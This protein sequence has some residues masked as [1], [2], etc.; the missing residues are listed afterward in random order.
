M[1]GNTDFKQWMEQ[2]KGGKGSDDE[3]DGA[4]GDWGSSLAGWQTDVAQQ[5]HSYSS[6]LPDAGPLSAEYRTRVTHALALLALAGL[7]GVLAVVVGLPTLVLR[8]SKF[9][10]CSTLCT[11]CVA[12]SMVVLKRPSVFLAELTASAAHFAASPVAAAV[13]ACSNVGGVSGGGDDEDGGHAPAPPSS[14]VTLLVLLLANCG[15]IY[16]TVAYHSYVLTL[17]ASAAQLLAA[18]WFLLSAIP[19]GRAALLVLLKSGWFLFVRPCMAAGWGA[20]GLCWGCVTRGAAALF[21]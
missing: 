7:F 15:T 11:L 8:P 13:S 21:A 9:V 12:A 14:S 1:S 4:A 5:L 2:R 16:V 3:T 20:F 18:A 6:L 19:G 10:L 17:A